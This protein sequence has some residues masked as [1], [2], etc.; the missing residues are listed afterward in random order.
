VPTRSEPAEWMLEAIGAAPGSFSEVDWHQTWRSSPEYQ[1][2]Q[3]ELARLRSLDT[4]LPSTDEKN[5]PNSHNEFAAPLWQQFLIVTQRVLQQSWRMPS[6]I[7]SKLRLCIAL[8][9]FVG[10]VF[11]NAPLTIQGLQNQ[12][13]D[14]FEL[15]SILGH[16]VDQ[17]MPQFVTQ[18]SLYEVR[19]RPANT[20]SWKIFMLSQIVAEITWNTIASVFMWALIYYPVGFYKNADAA[21]Q[22]VERDGLMWLLFWQ[23]LLFTCTFAQMCILFADT[24]DEG[25]NTANFLFV[26]IFI[27]CGVSATPDAMPRFW[28]FLYR[29][30]PLSYWVSAVSSTGLANVEVTCASNEWTTISLPDG[31]TCGEYMADYISRAGGYLLDPKATSDCSYCKIKDTNVF[32]EGIS[33]EYKDR[34]RNFAIMWAFI[35][36]NIVA[37]L[38]LYWLVRMPKGKR[39]L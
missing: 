12:M 23:F 24:A 15:C 4:G 22:G 18:R 9:L 34:W 16:Q 21:G 7:Y 33:S 35:V 26:L 25:G 30:S 38:A 20:Y 36:F 14:I 28:I 19:E 27:L 31:Q 8:S 5:D 1:I 10:L 3:D 2:I 13:F 37:A 32:L 6:Y 17:Q 29:V 11:L 39:K